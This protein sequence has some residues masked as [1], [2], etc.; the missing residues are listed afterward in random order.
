MLATTTLK[1]HLTLQAD[2]AWWGSACRICRQRSSTAF[3]LHC[4]ELWWSPAARCPSCGLRQAQG[5]LCRSCRTERP[6]QARTWVA[7]DYAFPW[8]QLIQQ[9]K[10]SQAT[11]LTGPLAQCLLPSLPK[12][13]ASGAEADRPVLVP[14]PLS[15]RRWR[16]RGYNQSALLAQRLARALHLPC[17]LDMLIKPVER[18]HQADLSRAERQRNLQGAFLVEPRHQPW[19][20]GRR[21]L[22]VD[23]VI[24]T[25]ATTAQAAFELLRCGAARVDVCALARTA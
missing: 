4:R 10:F 21:V 23:D 12:D 24:T 13:L 5:Q 9:W 3:C 2:A 8:D 22:L 11:G 6:P 15:Q 7:F 14:V 20:K 19:L 16:E 18:P 1:H 17:R 25:G